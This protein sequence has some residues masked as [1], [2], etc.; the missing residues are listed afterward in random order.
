M[1]ENTGI[2]SQ[3]GHNAWL[4][5]ADCSQN[6]AWCKVPPCDYMHAFMHARMH[7]HTHA[8]THTHTHA[9]ITK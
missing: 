9:Y 5:R 1:S 2:H 7:T 6:Q 8:H 4:V 3:G